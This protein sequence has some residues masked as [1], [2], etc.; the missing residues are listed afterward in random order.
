MIQSHD[1]T[2]FGLAQ[3]ACLTIEVLDNVSVDVN[4][5]LVRGLEHVVMRHL[6]L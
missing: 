3:F 4:A 1:G 2:Y 6:N 5:V